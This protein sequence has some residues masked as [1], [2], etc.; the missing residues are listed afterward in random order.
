MIAH[1]AWGRNRASDGDR[2]RRGGREDGKVGWK[3]SRFECFKCREMKIFRSSPGV[4]HFDGDPKEEG[5]EITVRVV[6]NDIRIVVNTNP[7]SPIPNPQS[8]I[9][10]PQI[11]QLL[12][13]ELIHL[14]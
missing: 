8:P 6:P 7:Q 12:L 9:P 13:N 3:V 11:G 5:R 2:S 10:N 1:R 4:I 14:A